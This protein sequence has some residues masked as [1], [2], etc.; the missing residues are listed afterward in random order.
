MAST[1]KTTNYNLSQF[2]G[3]DKPAWLT[4]YNQDM[5]KIDAQMK[6]NA[7]AASV[8]DGKAVTNTTSIG[9]LSSLTTTVKTDLVSAVNEV[10]TTAGTANTTSIDASTTAN[11]AKSEADALKAYLSITQNNQI[12]ATVSGGTI[13][14]INDLYY[15]LNAAGTLGKVYGRLR[16]T[17]N[18][19]GV[20]TV[21][22]PVPVATSAAF[23]IAAGCYYTVVSGSTGDT[24]IMNA[25]DFTVNTNGTITLELPTGQNG[26]TITIWFPPCLYFFTDFGDVYDPEA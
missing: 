21:T 6:L 4:D 24:T 20:C 19:S 11:T 14:N 7:D 9:T 22:L 15:A 10:N 26:A 8:A 17:V 2:I 5:G 12:N 3:S 1:N 23:T 13:G 25:R 18:T 16:L